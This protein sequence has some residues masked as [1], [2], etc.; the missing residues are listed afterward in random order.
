MPLLRRTVGG[1][2]VKLFHLPPANERFYKRF[3]EFTQSDKMFGLDVET[4]GLDEDDLP[5]GSFDPGMKMRLIQFGNSH[6]AWIFDPNDQGW[7]API[8]EFLNLSEVRFVS[9][10]NYD[11]IQVEREFGINLGDDD[12][13]VDTL[14][15]AQLL[16]PGVT[17]PKDLKMLTAEFIDP[18]LQEADEALLAE[19]KRLAP[20]GQRVGQKL[21]S[22]GYTNV[23]LD[24]EIFAAYSGLDAIMVRRLLDILAVKMTEARMNKLSKREQRIRRICTDTQL[25][26]QR[27]DMDYTNATLREI[28]DE[29]LAADEFLSKTLGFSP[30]SPKLGKWLEDRGAEFSEF[31]PGGAPQLSKDTM[32]ALV[33]RYAE[34]ETL[35]PILKA[36]LTLGERQNVLNNLRKF[37]ESADKNG[38]V[39]PR[40]NTCAAHTGRMS[41]VN[42]P[43]Q[44]F[45]KTDKR[46]RGCFIA[47]DGHVFLD[48]DYDSQEIRLAVAY[49]GDELLAKV[50]SEGLNQHDLTAERI[51]GSNFT[52]SQRAQAKVLNFA[53]QYGAGPKKIA[54]QLGITV[55]EAR[56]LWLG[57]RE[58]YAGLVSWTDAL[59]QYDEIRNPWGRVLPADSGR[60][61]ANGNY[62]IQSSGRDV[63][64]DAIVELADRGLAQFFWLPI[65]DEIILEVPENDAELLLVQLEEAMHTEVQGIEMTATAEILGKRW[66]GE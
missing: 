8:Y 4:T 60:R 61:Y 19:F 47:R 11:V 27:L 38:F 23:P 45:K 58:A 17:R 25:R 21:K 9:H 53:Q 13:S 31:T 65:H 26:G 42:P 16:W 32:P 35:G 66:S 54:A 59:A 14:V 18:V 24:N 64:G 10:T 40:I 5:G 20:V 36:K 34:D 15:M 22:W 57:W 51:F 30:R 3:A 1:E 12:R 56:T 55:A 48:A 46:L 52:K 43:M 37:Y 44:T 7:R 29:Y 28:E 2:Q 39:H 33:A 49:S 6:E 41:I 63:L 50:I 62:A